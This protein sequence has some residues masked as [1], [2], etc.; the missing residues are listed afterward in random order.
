MG[1]CAFVLS[2]FSHVQLFVTPIDYS[3]PDFS[4]HGFSRQEYG[5][6]LLCPPPGDLPDRGIEPACLMS[7]AFVGR[8]STTSAT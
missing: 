7:S 4:V 6:R 2:L 5:N 1:T 8:F 3:P